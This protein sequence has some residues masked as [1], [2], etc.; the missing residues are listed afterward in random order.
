[1]QMRSVLFALS[2]ASC[3]GGTKPAPATPPPAEPAA[4]EQGSAAREESGLPG[5]SH[6][7]MRSVLPDALAWAPLDTS[8]RPGILVA[9]A[10]SGMFIKLPA[11]H[12]G[13]PVAQPTDHHMI[14]VAGTVTTSQNKTALAP[15][16]YWFQPAGLPLAA[17]CAKAAPCIVYVH[18]APYAATREGRYVEK[19]ATDVTWSPLDPTTP[20]LGSRALLWG[21]D[22]QPSGML[23]KMPPGS[24]ENWHIHKAPYHAVVLAGTVTNVESGSDGVEL[25]AGAYWSQ[26]G[27]YK[28]SETCK[29]GGPECL[30]YVHHAGPYLFKP[31]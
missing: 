15:G 29:A 8:G 11:G 13:A 6:E 25:P 22:A 4:A 28:H 10:P 31:M 24:A 16:S 14:V 7:R 26:P 30:V 1:M 12:A 19:R 3:G 23:V 5:D 17:S 20:A 27:G 9:P 2:V 21:D 18:D